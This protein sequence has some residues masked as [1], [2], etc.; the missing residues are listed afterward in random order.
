MAAR[1]GSI[2]EFDP[3]KEEWDSYVE[4]LEHYFVANG[5]SEA[6]K[7]R[8]ILLSGCGA[9][10][11]KLIRNLVA[12]EKPTARS[13]EQLKELVQ[14]H[15]NPKPS[16]IVER[17]RFNSCLRQ[18]GESVATFV[19]KLR[20]LTQHC[21]FGDSLQDM[22]RDRLVCGV[23]DT[24]LQRRLL[25]ESSLTFETALKLAT[26]WESAEKNAKDLQGA[27]ASEDNHVIGRIT[28]TRRH[29]EEG[30]ER[31]VECYRCKGQHDADKCR[32][33]D[34]ECFRCRK[35]GHLVRACKNQEVKSENWLTFTEESETYG[36]GVA[37]EYGLF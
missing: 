23:N 17:F 24:C 30:K 3:S 14:L 21:E 10:T 31:E 29:R 6:A 26:A 27:Q 36:D 33:R 12:P 19:A 37:E 4:R 28:R 22:L 8:A 9:E 32:F 2:G 18:P 7:K 1:H 25:A 35:K 34:A 20:H 16:V 15:H 13:F 11:Y 5:V